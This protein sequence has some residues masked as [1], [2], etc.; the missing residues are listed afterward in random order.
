MPRVVTEYGKAGS[1]TPLLWFF[2]ALGACCLWLGFAN[3]FIAIPP[4][5]LF[6]PGLIAIMALGA[7]SAKTAFLCG[8]LTTFAGGFAS[9]YWLYLPVTEVGGLHF[10]PGLCCAA[11]IAACLALQGGVF[12]LLARFFMFGTKHWLA[13]NYAKGGCKKNLFQAFLAILTLGIA[14]N[15]LEIASALLSGFPW[16][17]LGGALSQWIFLVQAGDI[18]GVWATSAFWLAAILGI[19]Y[20]VY[21]K[22]ANYFFAGLIIALLLSIYGVIK[23]LPEE[24]KM[25]AA[26]KINVLFVEGNIDQNRKWSPE[27]QS[28]T[29]NLYLDLTREGLEQ[30]RKENIER[31]LII[32]PET[33]L[34]FFFERNYSLSEIL[35]KTL[36]SFSSPLLFGAPGITDDGRDEKIYNRAFLMEPDGNIIGH[37]DKE[38]LVPF[39]EYRPNWLNFHFLDALLQG[40]GIYNEGM[41]AT[42]LMYGN[43]RLGM[44]ICYEGIFPWLAHERVANGANILVDISNDGWFHL[45]PAGR[46]HLYLTLGRCIET[47]RWLFRGTNTGISAI[48]DNRGRIRLAGP[49]YNRGSLAGS[50]CLLESRTV[51]SFLAP[52]LPWIFLCLLPILLYFSGA[53]MTCGK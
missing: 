39:G 37:Y 40:V 8:W 1:M 18:F 10:I 43:W 5:A 26:D 4:L 47:S 31:P 22:N 14:W 32:W 3:D 34:P 17:A 11:L 20:W 19:L 45:T 33:A 9:L 6:W 13:G 46:Q 35:R 53:K 24:N 16:L 44:L 29:L 2:S 36:A 51:Y 38:R 23:L 28:W 12:A 7:S 49:Q 25:A 21:F 30:A 27:F 50:G 15:L 48:I 41:D 52:W 42:P